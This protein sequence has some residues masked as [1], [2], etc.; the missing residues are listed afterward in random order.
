MTPDTQPPA[1]SDSFTARDVLTS[2]LRGWWLLATAIVVGALAALAVNAFLPTV[3]ETGFSILTSIDFTNSGEMTQ[4]DEDLAME[5]VGQIL[6]SP[7]LYAHIAAQ[8]AKEGLAIDPAALKSAATV[9]RRLGT[10]RVRLRGSDARKIEALARIWLSLGTA[11]LTAAHTHA[12][13]ADGLLRKQLSLE[14]CLAQSAAALPSSGGCAPS[15]VKDLQAELASAA[16]LISQE[17]IAARALSSA[18]VFDVFPQEVAP[19]AAV[20]FKRGQ[21]AAA[22][23]LIGFVLGIWA[24]QAGFPSAS[25]RKGWGSRRRR[26]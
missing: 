25:L 12:L 15:G 9:E 2:A 8:A 23:G 20:E 3:Y 18:V 5:S 22:G 26:G 7:D 13:T 16:L 10:W 21:M 1:D 19:A 17:R 14:A 6:S 11:D 4:F 24:L